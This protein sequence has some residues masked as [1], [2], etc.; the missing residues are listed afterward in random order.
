MQRPGS[1]P[2]TWAS[3]SARRSDRTVTARAPA[4]RGTGGA[5][6]PARR[7][8]RRRWT[9][10]ARRDRGEHGRGP[11]G[12][13]SLAGR[14]AAERVAGARGRR[15]RPR[16]GARTASST[17]WCRAAAA[18]RR[19][20]TCARPAWCWSP[21]SCSFPAMDPPRYLLPLQAEP[22]RHALARQSTPG[23]RARVALRAARAL[24]LGGSLLADALPAVAIVARRPRADPLMAWVERL[25]GGTRPTAHAVV[26]TSWRGPAR[27][28]RPALL[29]A[30]E[31]RAVGRREGVPRRARRRPQLL[32]RLGVAAARGRCAGPAPACDGA[33]CRRP[34]TGGNRPR[35]PPGGRAARGAPDRFAEIAGRDRSWQERWNRAT[36]A[37]ARL[38]RSRL[39]AELMGAAAELADS[40]PDEAAYRGW[41]AARCSR[42]RRRAPC[43][44]WR[45]TTTSRCGTSSWT[46]AARS[47]CWIGRRQRRTAFR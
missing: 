33:G 7:A 3:C 40:I 41:L 4:S 20:A 35:R 24:P 9:A 21:R 42:A 8:L 17:R 44:P 14:P 37:P 22:W 26:A 25:G 16:A 34:G 1:H 12:D 19:G 2:S 29:R 45:G 47:A 32:D 28:D 15:R 38:S 18:G 46:T 27:P 31:S 30:A 5:H 39:E 11:G 6:A 43:P 13:R 10:A 23:R 36:A